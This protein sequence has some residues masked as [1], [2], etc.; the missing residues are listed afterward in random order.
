VKNERHL[1]KNTNFEEMAAVRV[2][3]EV[4]D[5][6]Q[7]QLLPQMESEYT[8]HDIP[9]SRIA[10]FDVFAVGL[11]RHHVS[12]I[13]ELD[14]T[15]IRKKL[16]VIK[17]Q[18]VK[19]SFNAWLIHAIGIILEQHREA[20]AYLVGKRKLM[21]FT[22][23]NVSILVEKEIG[24]KKVPMPLVI[25]RASQKSPAEITQEIN[26]AKSHALTEK[27]VVLNKRAKAY[28]RWYYYLPGALR[29]MIWRWML[30][31]PK[32]AY[33]NMG[34]VLITSVGMMGR[35]NGWFIHRS[36][37]PISFGIGSIVKKPV[38]IGD[39]IQIREILNTTIL[40]DHD[41]IDGAPMLRLVRD[42]ARYIE[43]G[44]GAN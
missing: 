22:D 34:N 11:S 24:G 6:R 16:S 9:K 3:S 33:N 10:T 17:N 30:R 44:E 39:E 7:H 20:T 2:A 42:L 40:L 23:I 15:E 35:L 31:H 26:Q 29:R 25:E 19:V 36:V 41:V 37:H 8:Y 1:Q 38:V 18:G 21:I 43:A 12:A 4:L 13:L 32:V 14:V 28:E 27:D 5:T